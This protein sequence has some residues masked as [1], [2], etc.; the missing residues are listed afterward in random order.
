MLWQFP[1]ANAVTPPRGPA[2]ALGLHR[3]LEGYRPTPLHRNEA[4]A[5]AL[6]VGEVWLKDETSRLGT[7]S[8]K[9]LGASWAVCRALEARLSLPQLDV[10]GHPWER[11][12]GALAEAASGVP[13][14]T[15]VCATEGNH[16][17]AVA[18]M[19]RLLRL[20]AEVFVSGQVPPH[21][22][23]ALQAEGA[24]VRRIPGGYDD[25]VLAAHASASALRLLISDM[26]LTME[27]Q[28][29]G[30]SIEGYATLFVEAEEQLA[31]AGG[32]PWASVFVP[33]GVGA[34]AAAAVRHFG[35]GR[36][37]TLVAVEPAG[38]ACVLASLQRGELGSVEVE[39]SS[40]RGLNCGRPSALAWA[41]LSSGIGACV[42]VTDADAES[43]RQTLQT[44]GI[45]T[46][47]AGAASLA[48][49]REAAASAP[50]PRFL[51]PASS[52]LLLVTEGVLS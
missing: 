25:A 3:R 40:L 8:F 46:G 20:K 36:A 42:T 22:E 18:R 50:R 2:S 34:L 15:L 29:P 9:I 7:A 30:W 48:G 51:E 28:V 39:A 32:K 19:A 37:P 1:T 17:L 52:L 6:G 43:A 12:P 4:L 47:P 41:E 26:A 21:V 5:R 45:H 35:S 38:A 23:A 13:G 49:A 11:S 33:V 27:E 14:L 10:P 24:R 16:G 31:A 44:L